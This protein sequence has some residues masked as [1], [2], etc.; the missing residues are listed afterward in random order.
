MDFV[1][2]ITMKKTNAGYLEG[3][4]SIIFNLILFALK[5]W[6][7]IISGSVA[8]V[9]DAWHTL[10]DSASS[11]FLII[12]TKLSRKKPDNLHPFGHGRWEYV[13]SIF[14]GF[15]LGIIAYEILKESIVQFTEGESAN[16]GTIAIVVTILSILIKEGLAQYAFYL[17]K[18]TNNIAIKAD[19]WH[20]RS[21]ALSSVIVLIGIFLKNYF[22][23]IDSVLGIIISLMLFYA[24]YKILQDSITKILGESP[25]KELLDKIKLIIDKVSEKDLH[26]HHFHLHNYVTHTELTFHINMDKHTSVDESHKLT[27]LI[28][29]RIKNELHIE[30][31]I[32]VDPIK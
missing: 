31:T 6:A 8:L 20:H 12:G 32:H 14:I 22:W 16:F 27:V 26:P 2:A 17:G 30:S 24:V 11:V 21:D 15:L 3:I 5:L 9:A 23:W 10:S 18:K 25:N 28:Q 19:G 29:K 13:I 1:N 4:I 7:G